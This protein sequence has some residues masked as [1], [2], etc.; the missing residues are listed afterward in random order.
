MQ[1]LRIGLPDTIVQTALLLVFVY[2]TRTEI[3]GSTPAE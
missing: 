2:L 1:F 3:G